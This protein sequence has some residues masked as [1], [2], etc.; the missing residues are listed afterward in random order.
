MSS[1]EEIIKQSMKQTADCQAMA[2][3]AMKWCRELEE[4]VTILEGK[5]KLL[6]QKLAEGG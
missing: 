1:F 6:E 4:Y 5:N 3:K 2:N